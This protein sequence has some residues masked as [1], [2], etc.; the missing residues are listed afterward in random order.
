MDH[1]HLRPTQDSDLDF[2]LA[3]ESAEDNRLFVGQWTRVQHLDAL[4]DPDHR[5]FILVRPDQQVP[6]GYLILQGLTDVNRV[7]QIRRIVVTEK[8][9][10]YGRQALQAAKSFAFEQGDVH[11]LWLD[12]KTYNPRAQHLY[13]SEGFVVEG[14]LRECVKMGDRFAS[15]TVMSILRHEYQHQGMDL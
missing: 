3:A 11:R 14:T 9:K 6:V 12:V 1:I 15:L 8:G 7:V 4:T 2:V 13:L 10:G 5:H